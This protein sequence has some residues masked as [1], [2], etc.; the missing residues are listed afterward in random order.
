MTGHQLERES[1]IVGALVRGA[2]RRLLR[3]EAIAF[4]E[5]KG[6]INSQFVVTASRPVL[7]ALNS[8]GS[9]E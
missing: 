7:E 1:F 3:R 9:R 5:D 4:V 8:L 6:F 2:F